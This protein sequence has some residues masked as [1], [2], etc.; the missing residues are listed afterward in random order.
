M[1]PAALGLAVAA[2]LRLR[3]PTQNVYTETRLWIAAAIA[4]LLVSAVLVAVTLGRE[5]LAA[6]RTEALVT[7]GE[8]HR[9]FLLRLDHEL[10]NPVTAIQAGLANLPASGAA[11]SVSAQ[12]RR[13]ADLVADLRKLAELETRPLE[14][15]PVDVAEMLTEI[16]EVAVELPGADQRALTLSLPQAPWP[17]GTIPGDRDLLFLAIHNLVVN[18]VKFSHPGDRIEMR[19]RDEGDH[20]V[21]EVADTGI[22]I[23]GDEVDHIWDDLARGSAAAG[24]PGSGLGL[25][26]ARVVVGRHGGSVWVRSRVGDGTVMGLRLPAA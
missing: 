23:P 5:R 17:V 6:A 18:A 25:A 12:A 13:L 7:A 15:A 16:H 9:R 3:S 14:R 19:A 11:A 26:L 20:V 22:G 4:G 24:T 1:A 21:V 10:K 8:E 2:F